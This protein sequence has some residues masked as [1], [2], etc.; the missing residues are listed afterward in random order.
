MTGLLKKMKPSVE[1]V[2]NEANESE[3]NELVQRVVESNVLTTVE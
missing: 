1:S 2:R 3:A